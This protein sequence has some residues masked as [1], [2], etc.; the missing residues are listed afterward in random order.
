M[1]KL[2]NIKHF[3]ILALAGLL[4]TSCMKEGENTIVLPLPNGKIPYEVIP[5]RLQDSLLANGFVI[6]EGI[7]QP[8]IEGVYLASPLNL[9]YSSDGYMNNFYD[10]TMTLGDQKQRGMIT[11]SERQRDTVEGES[12]TAQV[13]GHDSCFT[14]YCYQYIS[15]YSG[16]E[17]L[18]RCK[19]ATVI[20]GIATKTGFRNCQYSYIMLDKEAINDYYYSQLTD[21]ETFRIYYDGD[22]L[23]TKIR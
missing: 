20:S 12:I 23:A 3:T 7:T 16:A 17:Q 13:I 5:E 10:L 8:Y 6:N 1:R 21:I 9:Q 18:W 14:M 15:E 2:A 22:S 19:I 4:F 11:Y